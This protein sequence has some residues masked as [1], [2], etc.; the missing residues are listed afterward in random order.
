MI[1]WVPVLARP[2]ACSIKKARGGGFV[3]QAQFAFGLFDGA[4]V[5]KDTALGKNAM[6][7]GHQRPG[8]AGRVAFV[9]VVRKRVKSRRI[10]PLPEVAF[11]N[12]V[13][14]GAWSGMVMFSSERMNFLPGGN[15]GKGMDAP[16]PMEYTSSAGAVGECSCG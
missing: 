10:I 14:W 16:R 3:K 6:E 11:V 1:S 15:Q 7:V 12:A 5:Q 8:V 9:A 4:G 2:P 13:G